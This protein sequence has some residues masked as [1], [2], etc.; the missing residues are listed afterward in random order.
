[1]SISERIKHEESNTI[2][3]D[4]RIYTVQSRCVS[5][6][7]KNKRDVWIFCF[8][9]LEKKEWGVAVNEVQD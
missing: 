1:M 6:R 7:V 4:F 9:V 3:V 2:D 5:S 8:S